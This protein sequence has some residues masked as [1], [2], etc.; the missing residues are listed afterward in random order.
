MTGRADT[1]ARRRQLAGPDTRRIF[2]LAALAVVAALTLVATF[3]PRQ[4]A[5]PMNSA[6]QPTLRAF[7]A[8]T[9]SFLVPDQARAP[10]HF[11]Q[12]ESQ[13]RQANASVAFTM[14]TDQADFEVRAWRDL[15]QVGRVPLARPPVLDL[16]RE[17]A[18][19]VWPVQG[20]APASLLRANGLAAERVVLEHFHLELQVRADTGGAVPATPA[21]TGAVIP[22]GLFT[23]PRNQWPLP[24]PPPTAPPLTVTLAR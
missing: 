16:A 19:L 2:L 20:I 12:A 23:I 21:G 5:A 6:G 17:V 1:Q 14:W 10:E 24:A 7:R 18:V 11:A 4:D 22:Y 13:A 9:G 3:A 15:L 8:A